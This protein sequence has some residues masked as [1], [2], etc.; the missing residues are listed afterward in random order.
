MLSD[1]EV[2]DGK[3]V[4]RSFRREIDVSIERWINRVEMVGSRKEPMLS[5][6]VETRVAMASITHNKRA[7]QS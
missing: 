1:L 5:F 2:D 7:R 6:Q 4:I 3:G